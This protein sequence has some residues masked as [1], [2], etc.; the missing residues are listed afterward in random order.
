MKERIAVFEATPNSNSANCGKIV[1]SIPIIPPTKALTITKMENCFQFSF[2]P[3]L[4]V[5]VIVVYFY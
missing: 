4:I 1:L 2:N 3:I 5:F